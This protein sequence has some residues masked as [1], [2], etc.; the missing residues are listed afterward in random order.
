MEA[1]TS[2][3]ATI[4]TPGTDN[5]F[6]AVQPPD[7]FAVR[8]GRDRRG[9]RNGVARAKRDRSP[10]EDECHRE[11][12]LASVYGACT[13]PWPGSTSGV[14]GIHSAVRKSSRCGTA[15]HARGDYQGNGA[16]EHP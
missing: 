1:G 11:G 13:E 16:R 10:G 2:T 3:T 9:R 7:E 8:S 6:N 12:Q 15:W 5:T 14:A 4:Y